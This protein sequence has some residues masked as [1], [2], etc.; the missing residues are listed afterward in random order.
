MDE[1]TNG[2]THGIN[3]RSTGLSGVVGGM[4]EWAQWESQW[5]GESVSECVLESE[6]QAEDN[7][8]NWRRV[9]LS[10][11][12]SMSTRMDELKMW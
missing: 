7:W 12:A 9:D 8:V 4:G 1:T 2:N 11:W 10:V 5:V 6:R 3:K